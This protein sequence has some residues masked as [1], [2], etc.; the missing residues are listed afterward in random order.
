LARLVHGRDI[1]TAARGA[2]FANGKQAIESFRSGKVWHRLGLAIGARSTARD[3]RLHAVR[4]R[5]VKLAIAAI[6][7]QR[8]AASGAGRITIGAPVARR[9]LLTSGAA[10][11]VP[12][13]RF[14]NGRRV[15][16]PAARRSILARGVAGQGAGLTQ[17]A[18][19]W[20]SATEQRAAA[21]ATARAA[22]RALQAARAQRLADF[23]AGTR[24]LRA[25]WL[26]GRA[27]KA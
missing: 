15:V 23:Q 1:A 2:G 19:A 4:V 21:V 18:R 26:S 9:V 20:A 24:G 8:Q 7:A 17:A 27:V 6:Q 13:N 10:A 3:A 5:A 11:V 25:G 12:D 14:R 22:R 16:R